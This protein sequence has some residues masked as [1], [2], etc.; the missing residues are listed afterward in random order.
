MANEMAK[1]YPV[2]SKL[3]TSKF[4]WIKRGNF[5]QLLSTMKFA[6]ID[7][8][9]LNPLA[10]RMF[11][12]LMDTTNLNRTMVN[13]ICIDK[14]VSFSISSSQEGWCKHNDYLHSGELHGTLLS[15]QTLVL[16]LHA[17]SP[18]LSQ[19]ALDYSPIHIT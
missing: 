12:K 14:M 16:E 18:S 9:G 6:A 4:Q 13:E 5:E 19:Y 17:L 1:Q 2:Y 8:R 15:V 7:K 10:K 11:R 3:V